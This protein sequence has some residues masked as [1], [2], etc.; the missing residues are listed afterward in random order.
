MKIIKANKAKTKIVISQKEWIQIGKE[1]G[2]VKTSGWK[3]DYKYFDPPTGWQ[4]GSHSFPAE[5]PLQTAEE[6]ARRWITRKSPSAINIQVSNMEQTESDPTLSPR[7]QEV[8]QKTPT[9]M[10]DPR[11]PKQ[12]LD[13]P[14]EEF[15][16]FKFMPSKRP[17]EEYL[18]YTE[19]G[20]PAWQLDVP[21]GERG[22]PRG[23]MPS[24]DD[25][26]D[27]ISD[28]YKLTDE[29]K[30]SYYEKWK[31]LEIAREE[32][33]GEIANKAYEATL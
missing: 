21:R 16:R 5:M 14:S 8:T 13:Q 22:W 12:K 18:E 27:L 10:R 32:A 9:R 17:G 15:S 1:A 3:F 25:Y 6:A 31:N 7:T 11:A 2:W 20:Y 29:Q 33:Q 30:N 4:D 28:R 24:I 26:I 19:G 23:S